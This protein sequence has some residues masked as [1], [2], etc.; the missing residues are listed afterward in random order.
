MSTAYDSVRE[1]LNMILNTTEM[2]SKGFH[3]NEYLV[4]FRWISQNKMG[5]GESLKENMSE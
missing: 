5:V 2:E 4:Y 1:C 3:Q